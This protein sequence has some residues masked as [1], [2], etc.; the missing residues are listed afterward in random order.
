MKLTIDFVLGKLREYRR[1]VKIARK[2]TK[3][4][5]RNIVKV[6]AV[7]MLMLGALGFAVQFISNMVKGI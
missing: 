5:F 1:I 6:A 4:E 7:G 2:P 3:E